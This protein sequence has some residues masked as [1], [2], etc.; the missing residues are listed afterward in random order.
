MTKDKQ[1]ILRIDEKLKERAQKKAFED[2]KSLSDLIRELLEKY[3]T[4][5]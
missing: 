2:G 1:V 5:G 3:V 4:N